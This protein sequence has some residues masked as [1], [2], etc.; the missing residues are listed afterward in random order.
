MQSSESARLQSKEEGLVKASSQT[1]SWKQHFSKNQNSNQLPLLNTPRK[2]YDAYP[3]S[4]R[5]PTTA[6]RSHRNDESTITSPRLQVRERCASYLPGRSLDLPVSAISTSQ[7]HLGQGQST[8]TSIAETWTPC[9]RKRHSQSAM[10]SFVPKSPIKVLRQEV[11]RAQQLLSSQRRI[12]QSSN[13]EKRRAG[14]VSGFDEYMKSERILNQRRSALENDKTTNQRNLNTYDPPRKPVHSTDNVGSSTPSLMDAICDSKSVDQ[15]ESDQITDVTPQ[16]DRRRVMLST[17][18]GQIHS[19][20]ES[21]TGSY[22]TKSLDNFDPA[23]K[24]G[25][26]ELRL[27]RAIFS[28]VVLCLNASFLVAALE[29]KRHVWVLVFILFIKSKDV[30]STIISIFFLSAQAIHNST[31]TAP[32]PVPTKWIL[33]LISAYSETD[34]QIMKTIYSVRDHDLGQHKQVMCIVLDGKPRKFIAHMT[35]T[36]TLQRPYITSKFVHG[37]LLVHAG[38]MGNV[39]TIV[40]EKAQNAGK[41]DSLILCHDLFNVMRENVPIHTKQLRA[42]MWT[43][44]LPYLTEGKG[45]ISFDMIFCIDADSVIHKGAMGGLADAISRDENAIAACGI[46]LAEMKP[47]A[48]WSIWH[49]YQQFQVCL[50]SSCHQTFRTNFDTD[51]I[52]VLIWPIRE[53]TGGRVLGKSDLSSRMYHHDCCPPGNGWGNL[54]VR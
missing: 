37:E 27:Q 36:K 16:I 31:N 43:R 5:T 8:N 35:G 48:E 54:Q 24:F 49:L 30:L 29:S 41:K 19:V 13:A 42:E 32:A 11:K 21:T 23:R 45:L 40:I 15:S 51:Q 38:F 50:K 10:S 44:V 46:I 1:P 39:P 9:H 52:K 17:P 47:G 6:M 3:R 12:H 28:L 25:L 18:S 22:F 7:E 20:R 2:H 4:Q 34:E 26:W 53:K 14:A 33:S